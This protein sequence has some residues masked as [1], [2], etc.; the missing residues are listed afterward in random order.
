[1]NVKINLSSKECSVKNFIYN[2]IIR[3]TSII[4]IFKFFYWNMQVMLKNII[5]SLVRKN[6]DR[7]EYEYW[8][9]FM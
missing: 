1:M 9:Y 7:S 2:I 5:K 8:Q 3:Q 6:I 4:Q